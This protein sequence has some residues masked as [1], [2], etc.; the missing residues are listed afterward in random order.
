MWNR[1]HD[2]YF[3]STQEIINPTTVMNPNQV[4]GA[5]KLWGI[6]I[7]TTKAPTKLKIA[8]TKKN[9]PIKAHA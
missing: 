2:L 5:F 1:F 8:I 3:F 7:D 6:P 9:K 4:T